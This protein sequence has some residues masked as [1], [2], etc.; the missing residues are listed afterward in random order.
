[1]LVCINQTG[2]MRAFLQFTYF[3]KYAISLDI[4]LGRGFCLVVVETTG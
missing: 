4:E 1:M 3:L 2:E